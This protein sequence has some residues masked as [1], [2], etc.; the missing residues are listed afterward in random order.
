[1]SASDAS[2]AIV[3]GGVAQGS[4]RLPSSTSL[5]LRSRPPEEGMD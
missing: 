2:T 1:M 4:Y 3:F 5:D